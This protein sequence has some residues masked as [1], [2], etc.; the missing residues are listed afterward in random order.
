[1]IRTILGKVRDT[2]RDLGE[3]PMFGAMLIVLGA[4]VLGSFIERQGEE[5]TALSDKVT[6]LRG[7]VETPPGA[8]AE[9]TYPAAQDLDPLGRSPEL[10]KLHAATWGT[11]KPEAAE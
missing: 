9:P 3:D 6:T 4:K 1:V 10:A 8:A 2:L 7:Q 11:G 5:L